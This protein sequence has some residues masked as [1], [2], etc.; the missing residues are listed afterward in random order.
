MTHPTLRDEALAQAIAG[1]WRLVC[2]TIEYPATGRITEP[3]GPAPEGLLI[4][5]PDGC[6]SAA[7]QRPARPRLS[8]GNVSAV[9]DAEKAAAFDTC[10]LY[11]GRWHADGTEIHHHV[12]LAMNP[13]LLGTRQ[14]RQARLRGTELELTA[15]EPLEQPGQVRVHRILWR[16]MPAR[17]A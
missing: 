7:M 14:V 1:G 6:M 16:R 2:W 3:F 12:D 4:Y 17:S 8:R 5:S 9:G 15:E 11:A 13:N 10:V